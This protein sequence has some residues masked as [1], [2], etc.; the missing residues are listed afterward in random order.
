[1]KKFRSFKFICLVSILTI[2]LFFIGINFVQAKEKGQGKGKKPPKPPPEEVTW[3][4]EIP[5]SEECNLF[6]NTPGG[7][8]FINNE[9][10]QVRVGEGYSRRN[11][12]YYQF[13]LDIFNT[14]TVSNDPGDY[15]IGFQDVIFDLD[16]LVWNEGIPCILP[17]SCTSGPPGCLACFLNEN[18]HP[19]F[20]YERVFIILT[21]FYDIESIDPGSSMLFSSLASSVH[22]SIREIEDY[23]GSFARNSIED[24]TITRSLDGNTWTLDVNQKLRFRETYSVQIKKGNRFKGYSPYLVTTQYPFKF[25]SIWTKY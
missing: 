21:I 18:L 22:I 25:Q 1:M 13:R 8:P 19:S 14:Q 17:F 23:H 15:N 7:N 20:G 4:V 16:T 11:G 2:A 6:G 5:F 12:Q 10:V 3:K 24:L 9:H